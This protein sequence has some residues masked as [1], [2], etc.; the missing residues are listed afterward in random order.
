MMGLTNS[1]EKISYGVS[2]VY[3]DSSEG[4]SA[5]FIDSVSFRKVQGRCLHAFVVLKISQTLQPNNLF[6]KE[7]K[8]VFSRVLMAVKLGHWREKW[9]LFIGKLREWLG[10][11]FRVKKSDLLWARKCVQNQTYWLRVGDVSLVIPF[12][13]L[14]SA[15]MVLLVRQIWSLHLLKLIWL[16][17][18]YEK[19]VLWGFQFAC[20][21]VYLLLSFGLEV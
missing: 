18:K 11:S 20:T 12:P 3:G 17:S 8:Y 14:C 9:S 2:D 7:V 16:V 6:L 19:F 13:P 4:I 10:W 21:Y 5:T 1:S 15:Y